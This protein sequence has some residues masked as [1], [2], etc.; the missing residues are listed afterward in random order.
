MSE[1]DFCQGR[2]K[3]LVHINYCGRAFNEQYQG[4]LLERSTDG[5]TCM[6][7]EEITLNF[8]LT[9]LVSELDQHRLAE[10]RTQHVD[11]LKA[12]I[13]TNAIQF[14]YQNLQYVVFISFINKVRTRNVAQI[15]ESFHITLSK[16]YREMTDD[17]DQ[18]YQAAFNHDLERVSALTA[19]VSLDMR[20]SRLPGSAGMVQSLI[21]GEWSNRQYDNNAAMEQTIAKM[22]TLMTMLTM[23]ELRFQLDRIEAFLGVKRE[24]EEKE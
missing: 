3:N 12:L 5:F 18:L 22:S 10:F 7:C 8:Q 6:E 21:Q 2:V 1:P 23:R 4:K 19:K 9:G 20:L 15:D 11:H 14:S 13:D 24:V 16:D 17:F